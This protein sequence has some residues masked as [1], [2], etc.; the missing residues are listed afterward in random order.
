M[1]AANALDFDDLLLK[2]LE[3]F[4]RHPGIRDAWASR[5]RHV[6]VDEY[7]DTNGV[8]YRLMRHFAS[9][10]ENVAVCGDPDQSIYA[11]RGAD[12]RNIL[13]FEADFP[14]AKVVRLEQNYRSTQNIRSAAQ[15]LIRH[16]TQRKEKALWSE[17]GGGAK[18][19]VLECANEEDEAREIAAQIRA[20][21]RQGT[22]FERVAIFYRVN[23]MQ[24]ALERALRLAQIPY[25]I[26]AGTEF[27]QR[28]E[29]KD[30]VAYLKLAVNPSDDEAL[31]RAI[32]V[33]PRGIGDK[34]LA[35]L[36]RWARDRRV[37]MLTAAGSPEFRAQVRGKARA[38]LEAFSELIASLA[39][40]RE[41]P[42]H[43]ALSRV[44]REIDY[45]GWLKSTD[46][47]NDIDR[48]AN[49]AELESYAG[50]YDRA[51]PQGG[52]RGFLQDIA[53]VSDA[54][55][56]QSGV[57]KVAMMTLHAAKGLEFPA[58][59]IAGLE[60]ELL[61]HARS[62]AAG[63]GDDAVEEERRLLYVGM[64]R[65]QERLFL[66]YAQMRAQ[67]GQ[68]QLSRPS[69][70]LDE[71]PR[72]FLEGLEAQSDEV[73]ALG[74]YAADDEAASGFSAGD[75][76][77]HDHFGRGRIVRLVGSGANARATVAFDDAG[78]KQLLLAYAKLRRIDPGSTTARSGGR[79]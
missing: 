11:W 23:F 65:A 20:L 76:V 66:A 12:V 2:L 13:D 49:V 46:E 24:R 14:G 79:R 39:M 26:V 50:E 58:V 8:Q 7:Q 69:R 57:T 1:R 74:L 33:P 27:Y 53:L 48:E 68:P 67:Y 32:Q 70:F 61:P 31:R 18:L 41:G 64:T 10:H 5:F 59:F 37:P 40:M 43:D 55:S 6:M 9:R 47:Q 16:N 22:G 78:E 45:Y 77:E 75:R 63:N 54:D 42:A 71:I 60:E 34:S 51:E 17:K 19:V 36:E 56:Y 30:L 29:I 72:E 28:R 21:A 38:G 52:L 3:I 4:D 62:L 73:D 25:Q 44:I 35:E 15:G